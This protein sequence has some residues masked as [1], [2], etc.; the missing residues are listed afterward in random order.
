[1]V[2]V[3]KLGNTEKQKKSEVESPEILTSGTQQ[4]IQKSS[5]HRC[6]SSLNIL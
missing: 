1:M 3:V 2:I 4:N 5:D 6:T